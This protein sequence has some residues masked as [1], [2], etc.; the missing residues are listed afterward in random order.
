MIYAFV[1][2]TRVKWEQDEDG[3]TFEDPVVEDGWVDR[4]RSQFELYENRNDVPPFLRMDEDDP[5]LMEDVQEVL[6]WL[7]TNE[8]DENG[9]FYASQSYQPFDQDWSY[10]YAV[11]FTRKFLGPKDWVEEVWIP[12]H[13]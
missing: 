6:D 3:N 10:S 4:R 13:C 2:C 5:H 7:G 11:H 9:T 12:P 8:G 1:T